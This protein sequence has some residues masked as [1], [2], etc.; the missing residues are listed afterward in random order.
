MM[1]FGLLFLTTT[2][3]FKKRNPYFLLF[4]FFFL[5]PFFTFLFWLSL[6]CMILFVKT[7]KRFLTFYIQ[8]MDAIKPTHAF[9][10][11][12]FPRENIYYF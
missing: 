11:I 3:F 9:I 8:N 6:L 2:Y 10:S 12:S 7:K 1:L 4:F 5:A